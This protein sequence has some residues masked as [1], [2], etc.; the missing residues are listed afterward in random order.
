MLTSKELARL[1]RFNKSR[2]REGERTLVSSTA[3]STFPRDFDTNHE[4]VALLEGPL[5]LLCVFDSWLPLLSKCVK[6]NGK[7]RNA[8]Q[9][10]RW[11][12]NNANRIKEYL[13]GKEKLR[14][15]AINKWPGWKGERS[16]EKIYIKAET[17]IWNSVLTCSGAKIALI[18]TT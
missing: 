3:T 12:I 10:A 5:E 18:F 11:Q 4:G 7:A 17:K 9:F 16:I 8:V 6:R 14:C 2:K 13:Q 1:L 15:P